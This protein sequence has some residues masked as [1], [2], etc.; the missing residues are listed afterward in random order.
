MKPMSTMR[1][2][3]I[4]RRLGQRLFLRRVAGAFGCDMNASAEA[5][6]IAQ[7]RREPPY[8]LDHAARA[9]CRELRGGEVQQFLQDLIGMLAKRRWRTIVGNRRFRE[10]YQIGRAHV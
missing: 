5:A 9:K 2:A 3:A 7:L 1:P 6:S 8:S 10:F 4:Q